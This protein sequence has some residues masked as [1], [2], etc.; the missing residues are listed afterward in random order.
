MGILKLAAMKDSEDQIVL[1]CNRCKCPIDDRDMTGLTVTKHC[2]RCGQMLGE[3]GTEAARDAAP[4]A[5]A[6]ESSEKL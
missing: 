2:P 5:F 3:W 1:I 4:A 6:K